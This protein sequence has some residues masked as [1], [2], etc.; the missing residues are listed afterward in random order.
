MSTS[1]PIHLDRER[2]KRRGD[3]RMTGIEKLEELAW[4]LEAGEHPAHAAAQL[5]TNV[6][7]LD[8]LARDRGRLDVLTQLRRRMRRADVVWA[9]QHDSFDAA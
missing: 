1:N 6:E 7:A 3:R 5:G 8:K 9:N 4:L 2:M